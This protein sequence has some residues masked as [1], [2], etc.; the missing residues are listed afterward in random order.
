MKDGLPKTG[1]RWSIAI[2]LLLLAGFLVLQIK[3][4]KLLELD[5]KWIALSVLPVLLVLVTSGYIS[6]FKGFGIE[7]ESRVNAQVQTVEYT[8]TDLAIDSPVSEKGSVSILEGWSFERRKKVKRIRFRQGRRRYYGRDAVLQYLEYLPN[9]EYFEISDSRD[10]F[11]GL[12]P[13]EAIRDTTEPNMMRDWIDAFLDSIESRSVKSVYGDLIIGVI[14]R[15]EEK[16]V[17]MLRKLRKTNQ[18]VACVV[19]KEQKFVGLVSRAEIEKHI[20]D[21]VLKATA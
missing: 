5:A 21:E 13:V 3:M 9:V 19:S 16:I 4:P 14:V 18:S 6:K 10:R 2:S 1:L 8:A 15:E 7:L 12:I 11:V 20:V 17:E